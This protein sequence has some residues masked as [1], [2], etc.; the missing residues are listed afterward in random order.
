MIPLAE[1]K[2]NRSGEDDHRDDDNDD[3]DVGDTNDDNSDATAMITATTMTEAIADGSTILYQNIIFMFT[4]L[5][6]NIM[7]YMA[8][9]L[10]RLRCMI[11]ITMTGKKFL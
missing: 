3:D 4:Q 2:R 8:P 1:L 9:I 11:A 5:Y 6:I 7:H 10:F